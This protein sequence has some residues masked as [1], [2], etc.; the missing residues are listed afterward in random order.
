[1]IQTWLPRYTKL[2]VGSTFLLIIAGGL[3]TSTGS[4][5]A[6]P[7]WPLSY[8]QWMPPM[9][10]GIFYEHGHRMI[11]SLVGLMTLVLTFWLGFSEKRKWVRWMGILA[12]GAVVAQGILGGLTVLYLLPAPISIFHACLAQ[13]FFALV[14]SLAFFTSREWTQSNHEAGNEFLMLRKPVL[15][16]SVLIFL[17]LILG[18]TVRHTANQGM[19]ISHIV[20]GFLVFFHALYVMIHV[21]S[22][23]AGQKKLTVPAIFLGVLTVCQ[24]ALGMGAFIYS[25]ML[26]E[27]MMPSA[28]HIFFLTAHQS[29][30]AL[31]LATSV[32]LAL[33]VFH[34][35]PP[36]AEDPEGR[37]SPS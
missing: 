37:T 25:F 1:M 16:M 30:G 29:F 6:V 4:G 23:Y 9:V 7:D 34:L 15:M 24:M 27:R 35:R 22:R 32:F 33:R 28:G 36:Q 10:G 20:S 13:T 19:V 2:L 31:L 26:P 3:V 17:Q 14:V 5:L 18:A 11:A 12:L 8:G 21:T